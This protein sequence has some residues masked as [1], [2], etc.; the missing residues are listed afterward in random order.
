M[1]SN[2]PFFSLHS[3]CLLPNVQLLPEIVM[4]VQPAGEAVMREEIAGAQ[5]E[6]SLNDKAAVTCI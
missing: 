1:K 6:T 3:S 5:S 2:E 4:R